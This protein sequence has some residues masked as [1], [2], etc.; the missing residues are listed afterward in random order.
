LLGET[1]LGEKS[2]GE[3]SLR[4]KLLGE[5]SLGESTLYRFGVFKLFG[6]WRRLDNALKYTNRVRANY[7]EGNLHTHPI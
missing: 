6:L 5:M 3:T 2:L 1:S 7:V 4:E